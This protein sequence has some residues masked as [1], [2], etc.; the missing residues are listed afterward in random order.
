VTRERIRQL[1][2]SALSK[3]HRALTR[4]VNFASAGVTFAAEA[5]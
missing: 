4:D 2:T 5:A 1:Q 3:L